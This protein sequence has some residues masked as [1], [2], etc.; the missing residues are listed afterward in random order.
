MKKRT[1]F[2]IF[3]LHLAPLQTCPF[4]YRVCVRAGTFC[5]DGLFSML[6]TRSHIGCSTFFL[7]KRNPSTR[8]LYLMF[9]LRCQFLT[10]F[11]FPILVLSRGIHGL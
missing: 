8:I 7:F 4:R 11:L 5:F 6:D 2:H 3:S 1:T 10:R 9:F